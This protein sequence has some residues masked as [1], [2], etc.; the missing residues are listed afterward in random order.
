MAVIGNPRGGFASCRIRG[1]VNDRGRSKRLTN[2]HGRSSNVKDQPRKRLKP[3]AKPICKL[4]AD[5]NVDGLISA[6]RAYPPLLTKIWQQSEQT[7]FL[8]EAIERAGDASL[9]RTAKIPVAPTARPRGRL[10]PREAEILDLLR[11]G[12]TN[13]EIAQMLFLSVSTVKVPCAIF[14]RSLAFAPELKRRHKM[15]IN[16][17]A[18]VKRRQRPLSQPCGRA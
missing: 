9:A 12:L 18:S 16:R 17:A 6:Y 10:S 15:W 2:S 11:Q 7:E 14:S 4:Y 1:R 8:L 3:P 5:H 13:S